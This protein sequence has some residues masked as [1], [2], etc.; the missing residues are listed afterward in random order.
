M[1]FGCIYTARKI[2]EVKDFD[3]LHEAQKDVGL[4]PHE[5]DHGIL[6]DTLGIVVGE[7]SLFDERKHFFAL[8]RKL[9]AGSAVIYQFDDE[10]RTVD[11]T[12]DEFVTKKLKWYE[13]QH[14]AEIGILGF[15]I[16]R[17]TMSI[18]GEIYWQWPGD[19]P[20]WMK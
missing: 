2:F 13:D 17:P 11:F 14:G 19:K 18:N 9:L 16:D 1:K 4:L 3:T 5:V 15:D 12:L 6:S 8:G 7:F 10:G 20:D